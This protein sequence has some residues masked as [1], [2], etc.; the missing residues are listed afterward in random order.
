MGTS[1]VGFVTIQANSHGFLELMRLMTR[2]APPMQIHRGLGDRNPL[3]LMAIAATAERRPGVMWIMAGRTHMMRSGL[4]I[5]HR[6]S[7]VTMTTYASFDRLLTLMR[8]MTLDTIRVT[9]AL[10]SL[11]T[12]YAIAGGF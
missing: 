1:L 10:L 5:A 4:L 3:F 11:V 2:T 9:V 8:L 7:L 12:A 6:S